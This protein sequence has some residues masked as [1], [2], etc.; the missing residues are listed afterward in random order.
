[1]V[2]D[3]PVRDSEL[4]EPAVAAEQLMAT[5]RALRPVA[6]GMMSPAG[7]NAAVLAALGRARPAVVHG[8]L[9]VRH[10]RILHAVHMQ[11]GHDAG[12]RLVHLFLAVPAH[13]HATD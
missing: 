7:L 1:M 12:R 6:P 8:L 2:R 10:R 9:A 13:H 4:V 11:R 3:S 5:A